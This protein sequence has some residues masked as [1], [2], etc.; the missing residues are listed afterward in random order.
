MDELNK[1]GKNVPV[2]LNSYFSRCFNISKCS[3]FVSANNRELS[4]LY[5]STPKFQAT[6]S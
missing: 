5:G 6:F 1:S 3:V 2:N 4:H